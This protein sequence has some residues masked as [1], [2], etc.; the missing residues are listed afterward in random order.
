MIMLL[1]PEDSI[2][3]NFLLKDAANF[4]VLKLNGSVKFLMKPAP[5][6]ILDNKN[7]LKIKKIILS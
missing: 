6:V 2:V 1:Q 4:W 5:V 3:S 7:K